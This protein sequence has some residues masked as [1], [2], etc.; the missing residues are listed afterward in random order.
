MLFSLT[1]SSIIGGTSSLNAVTATQITS[2]N[3]IPI[4]KILDF[5]LHLYW[6][7][8]TIGYK[9]YATSHAIKKGRSTLLNFLINKYAIKTITSAVIARMNVS[10][11][12][13]FLIMSYIY[14]IN[15]KLLLF[16]Y[17]EMFYLKKKLNDS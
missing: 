8:Q 2:A 1:N 9:I 13:S 14:I 6:K 5:T 4:H 7:K 12:I 11:V 16:D 17:K 15:A 3:V 10:K